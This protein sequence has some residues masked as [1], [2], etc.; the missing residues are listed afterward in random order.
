MRDRSFGTG[1]ISYAEIPCARYR[2]LGMTVSLE[3]VLRE[4]AE[5]V[6][7]E[8]RSAAERLKSLS[9]VADVD[10]A[11]PAD[12]SWERVACRADRELGAEG[13]F[14]RL[15]AAVVP[16]AAA[17]GTYVGF[18]KDEKFRVA[19]EKFDEGYAIIKANGEAAKIIAKWKEK[20]KK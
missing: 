6:V 16:D 2:E 17:Q 11:A 7:L 13:G 1:G 10:A 8:V 4:D 3:R 15:A 9:L 18:N 20:I 12:L 14:D 19:R 5:R